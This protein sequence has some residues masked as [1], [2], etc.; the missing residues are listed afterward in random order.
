MRYEYGNGPLSAILCPHFQRNISRKSVCQPFV[1]R[2]RRLNFFNYYVFMS[3]KIVYLTKQARPWAFHLGLHIL[4]K[5]LFISTCVQNE[6]RLQRLF[7][8]MGGS[9]ADRGGRGGARDPD[10]PPPPWKSQVA[11][12]F[13]RNSGTDRPRE[14][15]RPLG[16][17]CILREVPAALC[18]ILWWLIKTL[19][20]PSITKLSGSTHAIKSP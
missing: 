6:N 13:L 16:S 4:P 2:G 7:L 17:N 14:A 18:E 8:C 10:P 15:I 20:G 19:P 11:L 9:R 1:L 12:G 5:Y 3:Q